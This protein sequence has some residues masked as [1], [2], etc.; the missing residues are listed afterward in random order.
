[1]EFTI[2]IEDELIGQAVKEEIVK[3][4]RRRV[5][6]AVQMNLSQYTNTLNSAVEAYLAKRLT[7]KEIMTKIEEATKQIIEDK[8]R[9][10]EF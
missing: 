10:G 6:R 8:I 5:E 3:E 2:V 1:M 4:I 7:D 9:D